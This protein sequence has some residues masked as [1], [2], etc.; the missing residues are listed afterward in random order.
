MAAACGGRV[1]EV[2][3]GVEKEEEPVSRCRSPLSAGGLVSVC[4]A[5]ERAE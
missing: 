2:D 3:H 4:P 1:D 5:S